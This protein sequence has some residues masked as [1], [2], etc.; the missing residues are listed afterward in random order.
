[1]AHRAHHRCRAFLQRVQPDTRYIYA[2]IIL[3]IHILHGVVARRRKLRKLLA[4]VF[5]LLLCH[6]SG[7]SP[8]ALARRGENLST[9]AY[10]RKR[11]QTTRNFGKH[12]CQL[13]DTN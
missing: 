13:V 2:H 6:L 8:P 9:D 5:A 3:D 4:E 10:S 12:V 7:L 1:M 11:R